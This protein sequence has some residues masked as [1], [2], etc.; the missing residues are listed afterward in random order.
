MRVQFAGVP[1]LHGHLAGLVRELLQSAELRLDTPRK[2][3]LPSTDERQAD[4]R[5]LRSGDIISL[6]DEPVRARDDRPSAGGDGGDRGPRRARDGCGGARPAALAAEAARRARPGGAGPSRRLSR[7]VRRLLG[8]ELKLRQYE[9][10]KQFCD[11]IVGERGPE[12]LHHLWSSP[13]VLP[14]LRNCATRRPGCSARCPGN[15]TRRNA[16][17]GRCGLRPA[18]SPTF[19]STGL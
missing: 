7:L 12:A 3:R 17:A 15:S 2:L 5:P 19:H 14:T 4:A 16:R 13:D 10:G 1:W 18:S 6:V 11:A 8:L 9:Q